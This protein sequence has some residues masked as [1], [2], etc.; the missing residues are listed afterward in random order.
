MGRDSLAITTDMQ[1]VKAVP[2]H[3]SRV[4]GRQRIVMS[5]Q[6]CKASLAQAAAPPG[7]RSTSS[8]SGTQSERKGGTVRGVAGMPSGEGQRCQ[9]DGNVNEAGDEKEAE[10]SMRH[11]KSTEPD[12]P[13]NT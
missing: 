13:H 10:N 5:H 11:K 7:H 2:A 1:Q 8:I 9:G 6:L 12:G 4:R 3:D